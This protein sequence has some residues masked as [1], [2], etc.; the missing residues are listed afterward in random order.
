M[1]PA[2]K[3]ALQKRGLAT[4]TPRPHLII[5]FAMQSANNL[6]H[7]ADRGTR[8]GP[9]SNTTWLLRICRGLLGGWGWGAL[10]NPMN[11][12]SLTDLDPGR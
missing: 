5:S 7:R 2:L 11:I 10:P 1:L 12:Q 4:G 8:K 3:Q 9:T 6:H